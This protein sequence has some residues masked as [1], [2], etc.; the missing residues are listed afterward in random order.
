M[1]RYFIIGTDTDCGK[2]H[3]TCQLLDYLKQNDQ[4]VRA[5]KPLASGCEWI[6]GELISDDVRRLD[7]HCSLTTNINANHFWRFTQPIA[8]HLAAAEEGRT[9][10]AQSIARACRTYESP[11]LDYLLI[12]GAGGLMV[13]LNAQETWVDF[14]IQTQI[15]VILVVGMRLGCINHALLTEHVLNFKQ[16]QCLGWVA[17]CIDPQMLALS[18][19]IA[20]L[21]EILTLPLIATVPFYNGQKSISK[22][23]L[24]ISI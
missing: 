18:E 21:S 24:T 19:N 13:P 20:T 5:I 2:T 1:K 15:P 6:N 14:L 22:F 12:E 3:V 8:P 4:R 9:L 7:E 16:I 23:E 17:N 11:D 10:S